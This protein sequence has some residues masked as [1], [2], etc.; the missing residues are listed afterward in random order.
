[1]SAG[2]A[3]WVRLPDDNVIFEEELKIFRQETKRKRERKEVGC[4]RAL[5]VVF[6]MGPRH[7]LSAPQIVQKLL[8]SGLRPAYLPSVFRS[9]AAIVTLKVCKCLQ[10]AIVRL[11]VR[12]RI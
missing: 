5:V 6:L 3:K 7:L 2:V 9:F 1:M 4:G 10:Y 8:D 11:V 12:R